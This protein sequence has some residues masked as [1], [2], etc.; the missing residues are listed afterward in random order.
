MKLYHGS[1]VIIDPIDL[2][3]SKP[4]KDFGKGFYLSADYNQAIAIANQRIKQKMV[5]S[6]PKVT[7]FDFDESCLTSGELNVKI[8]RDYSVEWAEFV[9]KN[10]N[11]QISHP[12]HNYD[13]VYGPIADDNVVFQLRR[14]L[15]G[16]LTLEQL[17]NEL[18]YKHGVT[19]QFFFAN[20]VAISK[21]KKY[22]TN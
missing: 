8:F 3:K 14:Y 12:C 13:I 18:K 2:S 19:F 1:D 9:L 21:L 5:E 22:G 16:Y 15:S 4:F 6:E 17:V 11:R 10:R 20:E 7:I